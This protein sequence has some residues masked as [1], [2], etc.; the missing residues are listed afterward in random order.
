LRPNNGRIAEN[1]DYILSKNYSLFHC[2]VVTRWVDLKKELRSVSFLFAF[3]KNKN[4]S[5]C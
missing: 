3:I 5:G 2:S 4:P 1:Q